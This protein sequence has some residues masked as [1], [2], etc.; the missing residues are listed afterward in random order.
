MKDFA[1][2]ATHPTCKPISLMRWLCRMVTPP[3]GLI[4]DCFAGSGTTGQAAM[5]EGFNAILVEQSAD[6]VQDIK[7]RISRAREKA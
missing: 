6:Y 3:G 1:H 7:F 2:I 5:E 4:L